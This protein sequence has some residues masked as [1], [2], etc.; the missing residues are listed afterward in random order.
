MAAFAAA[1]AAAGMSDAGGSIARGLSPDGGESYVRPKRNRIL[2]S[3]MILG[4]ASTCNWTLPIP[5]LNDSERIN[6]LDR[7]AT[8]TLTVFLAG[9]APPRW[10]VIVNSILMLIGCPMGSGGGGGGGGGAFVA[11]F[12]ASFAGGGGAGGGVG[13]GWGVSCAAGCGNGCGD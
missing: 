10:S 12:G 13:G 9:A 2:P 1:D 6:P 8:M 11:D 4:S 7:S 3:P 5:V